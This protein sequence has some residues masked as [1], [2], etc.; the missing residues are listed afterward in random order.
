[1]ENPSSGKSTFGLE[2]N[3]AAGLCYASVIVCGLAWVFCIITIITDKT[4]KLPRFHAFQN[5]FL[6][7]V[8]AVVGVIIWIIMII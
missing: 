5:L 4:N 7:I 3:V 8:C 6:S 1:M 2:P